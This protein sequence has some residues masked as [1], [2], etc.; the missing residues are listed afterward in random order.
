MDS[1]VSGG[2][3]AVTRGQRASVSDTGQRQQ[4]ESGGSGIY[5]ID[6]T[7]AVEA[8]A[9]V[10]VLSAAALYIVLYYI[11]YIILYY[12]VLILN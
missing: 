11:I 12:I 7:R 9:F 6:G 10:F 8:A 1:G 3:S 2:V 5:N 4:P